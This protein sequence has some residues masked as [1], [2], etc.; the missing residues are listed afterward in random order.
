MHRLYANTSSFYMRDLDICE[1]W[2]FVC[3]GTNPLWILRDDYT[4]FFLKTDII[5]ILELF[6][7]G[8]DVLKI[9]GQ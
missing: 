2:K 3:P 8:S 1:F 7:L 9:I 5:N 4:S 6:F